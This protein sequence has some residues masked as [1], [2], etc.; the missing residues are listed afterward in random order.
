MGQDRAPA[1]TAASR[2]EK[3][4][5]IEGIRELEVDPEP[6]R[7]RL[8]ELLRDTDIE[9]RAEAVAAVW[10][11]YDDPGLVARA[12]E[13]SREDFAHPVRAKAT[14]ALGRVV[15]EGDIAGA[16]EPGYTP[17]AAL[18]EPPAE[19]FRSVRAHLLGLAR[20]E[21][22][23]ID[24]RRFALEGLGFLGHDPEVHDLIL[25]FHDQRVPA[26]RLSAI[27]A[28]GRSGDR[29]FE[30]HVMGALDSDDKELRLQAIWACGEAELVGAAARLARFALQGR[31]DERKAAVEALGRL[32]G[33]IAAEALLRVAE[34][35]AEPDVREA[36]TYALEEVAMGHAADAETGLD[37]DAPG[38]GEGEADV[39]P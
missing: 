29:R 7:A 26:A 16:D 30:E 34:S 24:E 5:E 12:L 22:K 18:G 25:A 21:S 2:A 28:M 4:A 32:G 17:D 3:L 39:T 9:V 31:T 23:A 13:L 36:A 20:D 35:D 14:S 19:L 38:D 15:Y 8:A 6:A 1:G 27:F 10:S 37:G 33:D 11:Y